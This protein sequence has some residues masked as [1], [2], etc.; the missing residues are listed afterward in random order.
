MERPSKEHILREVRR[1]AEENGGTP[2]G[3]E[4]F[5]KATGITEAIWRGRYWAR[6]G[7]AIREAG[8]EPN[9]WQSK[10]YDDESLVRMLAVLVREFGYFP[11]T[12][13]LRMRRQVDKNIPNDKVFT[14][15]LGTR[16]QRIA[17]VLA[18]TDA[19]PEFSDVGAI[20]A[21]LAGTTQ[22][23]TDALPDA[24]LPVTG[25]VYLIRM[26]EYYKIG[27]TNDVDR[28]T[29]ELRI[30]LPVKEELVHTIETDDPSGIEAYWHKRFATR[31]ANGEWFRLLA[32]DVAAFKRRTYM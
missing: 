5:E 22:V 27:R 15:R 12:P 3:V 8:F 20:C 14:S 4:R 2:V 29:R 13:D 1:L 24:D 23:S 18:F 31:N 32:D 26:A 17:K 7:D 30:Q 11:T 21:R 25:V 6:W 9:T 28:R 16:E 19:N 10:V